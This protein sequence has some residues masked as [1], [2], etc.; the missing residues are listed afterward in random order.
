M[1]KAKEAACSPVRV[2]TSIVLSTSDLV[3]VCRQAFQAVDLKEG[4]EFFRELSKL[5]QFF[6]T[7]P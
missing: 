1:E 3:H 5:P 6:S 7:Q 2:R 4:S